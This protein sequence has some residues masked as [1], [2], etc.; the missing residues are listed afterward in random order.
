MSDA[1]KT[2]RRLSVVRRE[3]QGDPHNALVFWKSEALRLKKR[4]R[5]LDAANKRLQAFL[6]PFVMGHIKFRAEKRHQLEKLGISDPDSFLQ[7]AAGMSDAE[8][9]RWYTEVVNVI[10]GR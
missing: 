2:G 3:N 1:G 8:F 7:L 6:R 4:V 5:E 10:D 9:S